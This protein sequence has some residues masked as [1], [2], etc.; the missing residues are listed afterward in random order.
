MLLIFWIYAGTNYTSGSAG[1]WGNVTGNRAAGQVNNMESTSGFFEIAGVQWELGSIATPF[2][3]L[4]YA[5]EL[6]ACHRYT[7]ILTSADDGD[8]ELAFGKAS[9]TTLALPMFQFPVEMRAIPTLTA[10]AGD[11]ELRD[12]VSVTQAVTAIALGTTSKIGT[13]LNV[14]VGSSLVVQDIYHLK[15]D[16]SGTRLLQFVAEL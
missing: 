2:E 14:T 5:E 10:T 3:H 6:T 7:W 12:Q 8:A 1:A 13:R 9:S 15:A 16:G 4:T 11:W